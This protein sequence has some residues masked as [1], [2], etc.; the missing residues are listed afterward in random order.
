MSLLVVGSVAL[1]S[2]ETPFGKV[3]DAVGGSAMFFSASAS[4]FTDVRL[5]AVIGEDFPKEPQEFLAGRGVDLS[6]LHHASGKTFR[7]TGRYGHDLNEAITLDTQ[8]NVFGDFHPKLPEAHRDSDVVFLAN[9]DPELQLEVLEQ[10]RSP[11]FIACDT[12]NLWI[13]IKLDA[14]KKMI[15]KVNMVIINETEAR[16]L[17]G[18]SN[19]VSA[20]KVIRAM[21]P[22]IVAIKRGEY[23][24]LLF[25]GDEVFFAPAYPLEDVFDPTGAGDTFA[26]GLLGYIARHGKFDAATLRQACVM[27]CVMASFCVEKFS[28]EN[29]RALD[30]AT[31]MARVERF[32][33]LTRFESLELLPKKA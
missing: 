14:L 33:A 3:T 17:S 30:E 31:I 11:K 25:T 28:Y 5:V 6:G 29:L 16:K 20:A 8:L 15:S 24:A 18:Q 12:M 9:I 32:R 1:D 7:W 26:G 19:V 23:G 2:V 13:D 10:V 21:G 4:Y 22:Q 27:G